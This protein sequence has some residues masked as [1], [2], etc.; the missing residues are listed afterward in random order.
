M[1]RAVIAA[2][3]SHH[4]ERCV[5]N[6]FFDERFGPGVGDWLV[7][8]LSIRQRYWAA[9]HEATS[10]LCVQAAR[11][12]LET[13]AVD[14]ADLDLIVLSTDTPDF[15]SP[16]TA[17]I[18]QH[19]LGARRAGSFDLNSACAGFVTG[20]DL[21]A[22]YIA[23]DPRYRNVLVLGGYVMSR[24]L[25]L[26]DKKTATL[27]ADGAGA[28]LLQASE[29]PRGGLLGAHL[30]TDGQYAEWMGI[31]GGGTR[32][33]STPDSVAR[34]EHKLVFARRFPKEI[35]PLTWTRMVR[36]LCADVG[37]APGEVDHYVFTQLNI[38]SI[39]ETLDALEVP[40]ERGHTVMDRFAYT[41]SACIP[42][43]FDDLVRGRGVRPGERVAFVA[44]GGG[45]SFAAALFEV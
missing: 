27:F 12:A 36:A 43:A 1:R 26:D 33:P 2:T 21:G 45:L 44:S 35:N 22:K 37:L 31:Y 7:E 34:N 40:R 38:Q 18:V 32:R 13:A 42:M 41:G 39:R 10:D 4:P 14:P 15:V 9:E 16:S 11:R 8:N 29:A 3:G 6:D 19:A 20:L 5:S 24:H 17:S 25:D 30:H 23:A 28:V